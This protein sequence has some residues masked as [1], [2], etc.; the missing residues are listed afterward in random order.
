MYL[1]RKVISRKLVVYWWVV[2]KVQDNPYLQVLGSKPCWVK[3]V[4]KRVGL[5]CTQI[6]QIRVI[7][8]DQKS[9]KFNFP[10]TVI[11]IFYPLISDYLFFVSFSAESS[12]RGML[13]SFSRLEFLS[14]SCRSGRSCHSNWLKIRQLV[15][16][17]KC[18][19]TERQV[20]DLKMDGDWFL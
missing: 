12:C 5:W 10:F 20:F 13:E 19:L 9:N 15:Y 17:C 11:S 14:S 1:S 2:C 18:Q 6:L 4:F 7:N 3:L 8:H 16:I